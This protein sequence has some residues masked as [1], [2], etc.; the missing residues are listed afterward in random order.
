M[1]RPMS[2]VLEIVLAKAELS[3]SI[4]IGLDDCQRYGDITRIEHNCAN[5]IIGKW[6]DE[7]PNLVYETFQ[8][9]RQ[10]MRQLIKNL[11][12]AENVRI[13]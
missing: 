1:T 7:T 3:S 5:K 10:D 8:V 2:E 4:L 13:I 9:K 6:M 12:V 11:K